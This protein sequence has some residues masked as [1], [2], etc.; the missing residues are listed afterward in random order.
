MAIIKNKDGGKEVEVPNGE[1][2]TDEL[3]KIGIYFSCRDG[4]CRV[5]VRTIISGM[6]NIEEKTEKEGYL[7]KNDRLMCQCKFK[8]GKVVIEY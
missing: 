5:C 7:E 8:G 4:S 3:E 6:K 1:F 2:C